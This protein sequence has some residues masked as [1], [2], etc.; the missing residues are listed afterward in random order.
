VAA[1]GA[2]RR[3]LSARGVASAQLL[4]GHRNT[5]H[6]AREVS[7]GSAPSEGMAAAA[8]GCLEHLIDELAEAHAQG[9]LRA[10]E[11]VRDREAAG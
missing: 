4:A 3:I 7:D 2:P 6:H 10:F 11:V 1:P 5:I 8:L 9:W